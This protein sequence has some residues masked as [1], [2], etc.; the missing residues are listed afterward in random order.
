MTVPACG[1]SRPAEVLANQ[2][3]T[4]GMPTLVDCIGLSGSLQAQ[5][6]GEFGEILGLHSAIEVD[7]DDARTALLTLQ[8]LRHLPDEALHVDGRRQ[9]LCSRSPYPRAKYYP[10]LRGFSSFRLRRSFHHILPLA[11]SRG[12][13]GLHGV[14]LGVG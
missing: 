1:P 13:L 14:L 5:G 8:P 11:A 10:M 6:R 2:P 7:A 3:Y 9:F 12:A 4:A